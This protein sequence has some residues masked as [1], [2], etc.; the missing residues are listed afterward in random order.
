MRGEFDMAG[1]HAALD[2]QRASR[3]L[4][5]KDVAAES[6]VSASTLTRI[7]QGRRPDVDGLALL[8]A[9]S[10]LD[11]AG[12]LKTRPS[13]PETLAQITAHLRADRNLKPESAK[14]L[15]EIIKVAYER[16]RET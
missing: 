11:A 13:D 8:L 10:G 16:F 9:W 12:F 7:S 4:T 1:F 5:W 6:G 3:G 14:A 15:E 2:S